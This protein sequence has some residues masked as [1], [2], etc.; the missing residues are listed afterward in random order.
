MNHLQIINYEYSYNNSYYF[1][2]S[3]LNKLTGKSF[4]LGH[5]NSL[6]KRDKL[7]PLILTLKLKNPS[8]NFQ[9]FLN[10]E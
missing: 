8:T 10:N 1:A 9:N 4:L 7:A 5:Y 3:V 2:A 6:T